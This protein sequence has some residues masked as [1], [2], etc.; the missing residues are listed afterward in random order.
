MSRYR[1]NRRT[2]ADSLD[3]TI[4]MLGRAQLLAHLRRDLSVVGVEFRDDDVRV[5][6]YGGDDD[7]CGWKDVHIVTI[8]GFGVVGFTEGPLL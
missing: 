7:R 6:P 2:L 4:D 1:D 8:D 5:R 3:T